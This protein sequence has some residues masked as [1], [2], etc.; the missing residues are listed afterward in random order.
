[1]LGSVFSFGRRRTATTGKTT[2]EGCS[3]SCRIEFVAVTKPDPAFP[4][5]PLPKI[6][7]PVFKFRSNRG[8]LLLEISNRK[9]APS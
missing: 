2:A 1:V 9:R 7:C 4:D 6:C 8:K 3:E 5:S